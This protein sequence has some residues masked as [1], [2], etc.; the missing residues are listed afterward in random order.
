MQVRCDDGVRGG[1]QL[2][3]GAPH[4]SVLL[5]DDRACLL[6]ITSDAADW[7]GLQPH[8]HGP[9]WIDKIVVY[10]R[11]AAT[12]LPHEAHPWIRALRRGRKQELQAFVG[13]QSGRRLAHIV[14]EP[15]CSFDGAVIG[16]LVDLAESR[17]PAVEGASCLR[18]RA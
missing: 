18:E 3:C 11:D 14:A 16:V 2:D 7:L 9:G 13:T 17:E 1:M 4:F 15:V 5:L 6:R 8:D 10:G 12:P